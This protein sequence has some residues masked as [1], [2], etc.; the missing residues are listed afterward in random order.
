MAEDVKTQAQQVNL[1]ATRMGQECKLLHTETAAN[2]TAISTINGT[3]AEH[4]NKLTALEQNLG[5]VIDDSTASDTKTY[6]SNKIVSEITAAKQAVKDDLLGGA[7]EAY[8]T[9]KELADLI[10]TN[11]SA[12]DALEEIAAGHVRFDQAQTITDEQKAQA[13]ANIGAAAGSALEALTTRVTAAETAI[14]TVANLKTTAKGDLVSAVNE[15]KDALD[16][17]TTA[18][19]DTSVDYVAAFEAALAA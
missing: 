9:L 1:L 15:V 7:G 16:A 17:L 3:L 2:A 12:I 19:G 14:G 6:S 5:A 18:V 4:G 13:R 8:N 10:N 11:K